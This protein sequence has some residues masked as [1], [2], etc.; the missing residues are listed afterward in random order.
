MTTVLCP[1]FQVREGR[2]NKG[3]RSRATNLVQALR[4]K[5]QPRKSQKGYVAQRL[6]PC[7]RL[8]AHVTPARDPR[9]LAHLSEP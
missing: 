2:G 6:R 4:S 1:P 8:L 5:F 3:N 9:V 7:R